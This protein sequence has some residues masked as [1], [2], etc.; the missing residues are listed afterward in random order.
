[1]PIPISPGDLAATAVARAPLT[2]EGA[3]GATLE[4]LTFS[5]GSVLIL[6][7]FSAARDWM[8][9]ATHDTGRAAELWVSGAMDRL[10]AVI[11]PG[12]VRIELDD[13]RWRLYLVDVSGHFLR[14]RTRVTPAEVKRF[15]RATA[16]MHA[17]FWGADVP[18]LAS[19][20]DLLGLASPATVAR[21]EGRDSPFLAMVRDGWTA[22]DELVPADVGR[23][24]H[25]IHDDPRPLARA[26]AEHGT[27]LVH[28]DLHYGN[29]APAPDR[30][31]VIDWGLATAGPSAIDVAWYLDQSA[32]FIE[33]SR[34]DVLEAFAEA[35]GPPHD[36]RT[37]RLALLAELVLSGWQYR[38]ALD[39]ADE[40]RRLGR[41]SDLAWW[42]A[43]AREGLE[44][45]G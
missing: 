15:L 29:V 39:G 6:K 37:L 12:I 14:A 44:L 21:E 35:E 38:V 17:A 41:R 34:E 20:E 19:I 33:A 11:D 10:P 42:V 32:A 27:T 43:R 36:E 45:L 3:S 7:T 24:V 16:E 23:A 40:S 8:M 31:Y 13:Q 4:R 5:D 9:R 26:M 18:G 1:M 22:L 28:A 25:R 30:F 2:A